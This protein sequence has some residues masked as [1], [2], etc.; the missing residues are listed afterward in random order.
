VVVQAFSIKRHYHNKSSPDP[1]HLFFLAGY[2]KGQA[3]PVIMLGLSVPVNVFGGRLQELAGVN[4]DAT[5]FK[6][7]ST[8]FKC[9]S[10]LAQAQCQSVADPATLDWEPLVDTVTRPLDFGTPQNVRFHEESGMELVE[11]A[12]WVDAPA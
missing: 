7:D 2:G 11:L 5:D 12:D 8:A 3:K 9:F 1:D 4:L 6:R 10:E